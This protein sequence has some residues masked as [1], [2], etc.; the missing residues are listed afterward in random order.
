[1]NENMTAEKSESA[2]V[3]DIARRIS[4]WAEKR[5]IP[6]AKLVQ[7]YPALGTR[8]TF[9]D[10]RDGKSDRYD[11]EKWGAA[12]KAV[13][14]SLEK[15]DGVGVIYD[16]VRMVRELHR[17]IETASRAW[18]VN[19]VVMLQAES[20][21][22][23]STAG[24]ILAARYGD[25]IVWVEA[26][27]AW[28]DKP[29]NLLAEVL[30]AMEIA[31]P[32]LTMDC[33]SK[34][35]AA[36]CGCR[37][38]LIIDEAHHLGPRCLNVLKTLVNKTPGEFV[39]MAIPVLWQRLESKGSYLE[40]RQVSTNRLAERVKFTL[41]VNDVEEFLANAV[42]DIDKEALRKAAAQIRVEAGA[43]GN[44]SYLRELAREIAR[45][46]GR[47]LKDIVEAGER[48]RERR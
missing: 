41:G 5:N 47:G 4:E 6:V 9:R 13:L 12:Y 10:I 1:M 27:E 7:K 48:V 44:M 3:T 17:A 2:P 34:V 22:G 37:K 38:C 26:S 33:L 21:A 23:K 18:D 46:D 11:V 16:D 40:A 30:S 15:M 8:N 24:R 14:A 25:R 43:L 29:R 20:G 19:R 42:P 39:L 45:R 28:N 36:L 32:V 35:T 31:P